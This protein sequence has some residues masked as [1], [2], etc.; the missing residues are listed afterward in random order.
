MYN[1]VILWTSSAVYVKGSKAWAK[2]YV[3]IAEPRAGVG[4]GVLRVKEPELLDN[5]VPA[6]LL[7]LL[8]LIKFADLN[9]IDLSTTELW[10]GF[11]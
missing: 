1:F 6:L 11:R 5:I 2:P 9:N 4:T 8:S 7:G 10:K 3:G